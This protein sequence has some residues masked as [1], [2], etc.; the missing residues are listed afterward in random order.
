M[1]DVSGPG[2]VFIGNVLEAL[3]MAAVAFFGA[4]GI[5]KKKMDLRNSKGRVAAL[6]AYTFIVSA[7][8]YAFFADS[9]ATGFGAFPDNAMQSTFEF[10]A[11]L[12][13][14]LLISLLVIAALG[15]SRRS[16]L[17]SG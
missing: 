7:L 4:Y 11:Q 3:P 5:A 15:R 13:L 17:P 12:A 1:A 8:I 16:P 6:F 14:S 10:P 2:A 9:I